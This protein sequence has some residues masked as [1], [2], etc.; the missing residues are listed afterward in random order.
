MPPGAT[1]AIV[2]ASIIGIALAV[3]EAIVPKAVVRFVPSA[4]AIG[5]GFVIPAWNA[6]S[7]FAGALAAAAFTRAFSE[8]AKK[9]IVVVAAGLIVGESLA[10]V[11][12]ALSRIFI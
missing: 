11:V 9:R 12:G 2:V 10:G 4:P 8:L 5:L 3:I 7:M 1:A 6:L